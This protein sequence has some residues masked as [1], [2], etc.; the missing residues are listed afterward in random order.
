MTL[1]SPLPLHTPADTKRVSALTYAVASAMRRHN[2]PSLGAVDQAWLEGRPQ[3]LLSLL[4]TTVAASAAEPR[5]EELVAACLWL[6]ANQLELIRYKLE[7][8]YDWASVVLDAYQEN[9]IVL[10]RAQT[11]RSE[12]WFA[13]VNLLNVAKVPIRP[14]MSEAL[15]K[16]ALDATPPGEALSPQGIPA[17]VSRAV[18][19]LGR[20]AKDPFRVVEELADIGMLM[21]VELRAFITHELGLPSHAVLR[22]AVPL[23]LLDPEPVVRRSAAAV[24]EQIASPQTFSP[25]MLRRALLLRNWIPEEERAA[26]DR[27]VRKARVKGVECA[28]WA[29]ASALSI[30]CTIVDGSGA[31]SVVLTTPTGRIGLFAGLLLKQGFGVRDAWCDLSVPR[32]EI[33]RSL[34]EAR[35]EMAWRMTG[36]DHLNTVVQH[37]IARGLA[38]GNLPQLQLLEI[39]EAIGAADWKDRSLDMTAETEQL[40]AGSCAAATSPAQIAL[41]LRRSGEWIDRDPMV[42]SWFEDG[43]AVR[44]LVDKRPRLKP[45]VALRRVLEEVLPARRDAW[46]ERLVLLALWLRDST[47]DA[48]PAELSQDCLVLARE[49]RAGRPPAELPAMVAI[50]ERS[51]FVARV[52]AQ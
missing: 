37:H 8:D 22:E 18:D 6:L 16:A 28:Q 40:L 50:A 34:K 14:E 42:Q 43:A 27:L 10:A 3:T 17:E 25:V 51:V 15:A 1:A 45:D 26:I 39:A 5:D 4:D 12:D 30:Q 20:S 7:R 13:L 24:L 21:P 47:E 33:T 48:L 23:L 41:S 9:L 2:A 29:P 19:E 46:A 32:R 36:R 44:A 35:C 31:Q 52:H 38:L 11:L 49:L